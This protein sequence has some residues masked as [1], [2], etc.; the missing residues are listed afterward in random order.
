MPEPGLR[1]RRK[2]RTR[3]AI[4]RE[5][6][7]LFAEQGYEAT[8]VEQIADAA[9]VS[10]STFFRHYPTKEDVVLLRDRDRLMAELILARPAD[11]PAIAAVRAGILAAI[12]ATF[13]EDDEELVRE[14]MGFMLSVPAIRARMFE[15]GSATQRMFCRALGTRT[16]RDPDT[17][18]VQVTA[19]VVRGA[20]GAAVLRWSREP[21]TEL[22]DLTGR[23]LDLVAAGF[24]L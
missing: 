22:A 4:Q 3:V 23:A 21:G 13:A 14:R 17:F 6:M 8:T 1:E 5:A 15:Q 24:R 20:L 12:R 18:E 7:R 16:G 10:P 19:A 9:E 2:Q 11:E